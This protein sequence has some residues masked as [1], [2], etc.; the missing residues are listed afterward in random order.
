MQ[1]KDLRVSARAEKLINCIIDIL[2]TLA[3]KK[4]FRI[5]KVWDRKEWFSNEIRISGAKRDEAYY[6]AL[7]TR[8]EQDWSQY[9]IERNT[10]VKLIKAKKKEYYESMIDHN[11]KNPVGMWKTLKEVIRGEPM[12]DKVIENI[13]FEILRNMNECNIVDKFK[14]YYVQSIENR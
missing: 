10:V 13:D 9:K 1:G 5:P 11:R 3:S 12:S 4:I 14:L 6:K 8:A 2:D 7:Y